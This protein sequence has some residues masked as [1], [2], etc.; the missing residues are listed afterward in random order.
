MDAWTLRWDFGS[1]TVQSLG[2]MLGGLELR[3]PDGRRIRPLAEGDWSAADGPAY[4][5][6]PPM[7]RE[8]RGEWPC[9]PFGKDEPR[10]LPAAWVAD[11]SRSVDRFA[12]GYGSHHGWKLVERSA[13]GLTI[14]IDYPD[15]H[16]VRRVERTLR[17][18]AGRAAIDIRLVVEMRSDFELCLALHPVFRLPEVA[19]AAELVV[20]GA[21]GGRTYPIKPD[22]TS[23]LSPDKSFAS[24]AAV[25]AA[26]GGALDL[27]RYPS[28]LRNEELLQ[29]VAPAGRVILRNHA[30][31]YAAAL[32]YDSELFPT[33]MLWVANGGLAGYP[34]QG[35]F[36]AL[37]IEP[38]RAAFDLGQ[39]V[40]AL[41]D[42]PWRQAG[43]P[44]TI[45]L[46]A[47][48]TLTTDY[49]ISVASL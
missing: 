47:G 38:A 40:S 17:G 12:H 26:D 28:G 43:V 21:R 15:A 32:D 7:I 22:P 49:R 37:G 39:A 2:G 42:N 5:A 9:I 18:I 30:E 34:W 4:A 36:R 1:A 46:A 35:R 41:P 23:R 10:E 19:G 44:T 6:L 31:G 27:T 13:D 3:L 24:P 16:P 45:R 8:L 48:E 29:I 20:E 33:L 25:P 14:A 11:T